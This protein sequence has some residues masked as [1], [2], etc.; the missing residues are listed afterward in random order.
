MV[1]GI[2]RLL[3]LLFVPLLFEWLW[4]LLIVG[5]ISLLVV[6]LLLILL[7]LLWFP[8]PEKLLLIWFW[9]G[10]LFR[11]CGK[12]EEL[13]NRLENNRRRGYWFFHVSVFQE[14]N[15]HHTHTHTH[16]QDNELCHYNQNNT[17][18]G[19]RSYPWWFNE[20]RI[21]Y[22]RMVASLFR[23]ILNSR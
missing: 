20:Y 23:L 5:W 15:P 12:K 9:L 2:L 14:Q 18:A 1:V 6:V 13:K 8:E 10:N 16:K 19:Y 3:L 4:L 7:L 11:L 21:F 22:Y 17:I